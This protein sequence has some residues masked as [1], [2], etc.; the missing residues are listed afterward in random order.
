MNFNLTKPCTNCPFRT[1]IAFYLDPRRR[2]QIAESLARG[3]QT[4]AC[5][6]TVDYDNW[7]SGEA[8]TH[9]GEES[10]CAG[11]LIVMAKSE[12]LWGNAMLRMAKVLRL[13]D[14]SKLDLSADTLESLE[15]F[16]NNE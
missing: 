5:H 7:Q 16:V 2:A 12:T 8:Y 10:H 4:F 15:D 9:H 3:D 14:E 11:A 6:K 1:D 13:F